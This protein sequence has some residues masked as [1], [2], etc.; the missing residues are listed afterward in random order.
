M[1]SAPNVQFNVNRIYGLG[2]LVPIYWY[3]NDTAEPAS[4]KLIYDVLK[5]LSVSA[6]V[7]I[8]IL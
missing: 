8:Q 7:E 3:F 2:V 5:L 1:P 4:R 6:G